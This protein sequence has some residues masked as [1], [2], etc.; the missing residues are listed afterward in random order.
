MTDSEDV[1]I[2]KAVICRPVINRFT[3]NI[4]DFL[5]MTGFEGYSEDFEAPEDVED[6]EDTDKL[7]SYQLFDK[8]V[9]AL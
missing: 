3:D 7:N 2:Q 8:K 6:S 9:S 5:I 4:A 1:E